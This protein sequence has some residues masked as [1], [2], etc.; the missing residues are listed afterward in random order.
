MSI[1]SQKK[2]GAGGV[3]FSLDDANNNSKILCSAGTAMVQLTT[4]S[5]IFMVSSSMVV[6][7][8]QWCVMSMGESIGL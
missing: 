4:W 3:L 2:E 5:V 8:E 6:V 1:D 7:K